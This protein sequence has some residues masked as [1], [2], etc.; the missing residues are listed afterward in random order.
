MYKT[1][2]AKAFEKVDERWVEAFGGKELRLSGPEG[3]ERFK[4]SLAGKCGNCARFAGVMSSLNHPRQIPSNGC[5]N[6]KTWG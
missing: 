6:S 4:K 2:L 1:P 3:V 5:W